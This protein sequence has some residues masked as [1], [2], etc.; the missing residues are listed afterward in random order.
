[1][2]KKNKSGQKRT[3]VNVTLMDKKNKSG[4]KEQK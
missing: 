3:K 1:M 4:Q 2:D